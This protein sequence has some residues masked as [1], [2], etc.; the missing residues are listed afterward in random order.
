MRE[1]RWIFNFRARGG[2]FVRGRYDTFCIK[3]ANNFAAKRKHGSTEIMETSVTDIQG[4]IKPS[5]QLSHGSFRAFNQN[6][7]KTMIVITLH[8]HSVE[9]ILANQLFF[10][11]YILF[12][13][14]AKIIIIDITFNESSFFH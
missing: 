12:F 5:V 3:E 9:T 11:Y 1:D 6:I 2:I 4:T 8:S 7:V 13:S 10:S 14:N